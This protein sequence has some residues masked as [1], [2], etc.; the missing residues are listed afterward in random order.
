M[1]RLVLA[2]SALLVICACGSDETSEEAGALAG[3]QATV[4]KT[5]QFGAADLN[6][7]A[8]TK[9][10]GFRR[11]DERSKVLGH[12]GMSVYITKTPQ[13]NGIHI[14]AQVTVMPCVGCLPVD[15]EDRWQF[16]TKTL[17]RVKKKKDPA[18]VY[19]LEKVSLGGTTAFANYSLSFSTHKTPRGTAYRGDHS[20]TLRFNNGRNDLEIKI[21]PCDAGGHPFAK[22]RKEL[23]QALT[24]KTL[25][26]YAKRVWK[27]FKKFFPP[28]A[29]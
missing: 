9:I 6:V 10:Y 2:L 24:K 17:L 14:L 27:K 4:D 22:S 23:T 29:E 12:I 26:K 7:I 19:R 11:V 16:K 3:P 5:P 25:K 20:Y 15:E 13:K 28:A 18:A 21:S 8:A 1:R